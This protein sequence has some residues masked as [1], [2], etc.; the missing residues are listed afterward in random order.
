MDRVFC[1]LRK[2]EGVNT[3]LKEVGE[4]LWCEFCWFETGVDVYV[5]TEPPWGECLSDN[6]GKS[7]SK[8][9]QELGTLRKSL[10]VSRRQNLR[11]VG[12]KHYF[13]F[14]EKLLRIFIVSIPV[15][16]VKLFDM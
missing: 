3:L 8:G 15:L 10:D 13:L 11:H 6:E 9:A 5:N 14:A 1:F 16:D 4:T 7:A 12:G 2:L